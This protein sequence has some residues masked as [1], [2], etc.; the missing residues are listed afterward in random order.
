LGHFAKLLDPRIASAEA[1]LTGEP[2]ALY[3]GEEPGVTRAVQRRLLEFA[4][5]RNC[6]RTAM[7]MLNCAKM[8]LPSQQDRTPLWPSGLVGSITHTDVLVAAA[9]AR[10]SQGFEAIGIDLEPLAELPPALWGEV[11]NPSEQAR[12]G[13]D[14]GITLGLAARLLFCMKEAA[15]KCQYP[16][17]RTMLEFSDLAVAVDVPAGQFTATFLCAAPPFRVRDRLSGKFA[18]AA[19]HIAGAVV[20]NNKDIA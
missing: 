4:H 12:L 15:F 10:R 9:V 11:C 20:I 5:G 7:G 6:A 14:G 16:M 17:S 13:T 19:D 3:P 2:P 8:A 18:V 1:L